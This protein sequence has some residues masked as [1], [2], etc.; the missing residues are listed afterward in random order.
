MY[1]ND[2]CVLMIFYFLDVY[3]LHN[4]LITCKQFYRVGMDERLWRLL[5]FCNFN[6]YNRV[7]YMKYYDN[8][9][10]CFVDREDIIRC[11]WRKYR[12]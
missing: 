4:C 8:Y 11:I 7:Q 2:D 1:V 6:T 12:L 3:E 9:R 5:Y 10:C